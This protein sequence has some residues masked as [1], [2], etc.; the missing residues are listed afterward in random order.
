MAKEGS[1]IMLF[2][3]KLLGEVE[4]VHNGAQK[5]LNWC[6]ILT[7]AAS[8]KYFG[9]VSFSSLTNSKNKADLGSSKFNCFDRI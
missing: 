4:L 8:R 1:H 3:P 6:C 2:L 7:F 5:L 9:L